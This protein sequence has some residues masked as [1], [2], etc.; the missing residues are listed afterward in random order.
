MNPGCVIVIY[1]SLC[2]DLFLSNEDTGWWGKALKNIPSLQ[3]GE[4]L[5]IQNCS[6][7]MWATEFFYESIG[8]GLNGLF[9]LVSLSL[10][11]S[12]CYHARQFCTVLALW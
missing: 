12:L 7:Y 4:F 5:S 11:A 10:V 1:V 2:V 8:S 9:L 6:F 3:F